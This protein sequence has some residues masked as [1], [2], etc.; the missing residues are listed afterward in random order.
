MN[1]TKHIIVTMLLPITLLLFSFKNPQ[2]DT[3]MDNADAATLVKLVNNVRTQGCTCGDIKMPAVPPINWSNTL[4]KVAQ[5]HSVYMNDV[6]ELKHEGAKKEK[7]GTRLTDAGYVWRTYGENVAMGPKTEEE[8]IK[9][10]LNSPHHCQNI[11]KADFTE[12]GVGLSGN[13]WTQVFAT[14]K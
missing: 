14:P 5:G 6:N 4:Q 11:M 9:V 1:N 7:A 2:D 13:Y 12:M 10:W 8:A 3:G